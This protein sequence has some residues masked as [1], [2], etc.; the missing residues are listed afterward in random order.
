MINHRIILWASLCEEAC[1]L[2]L[3][4]NGVGLTN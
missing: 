4:Y 1:I 2:K 3:A